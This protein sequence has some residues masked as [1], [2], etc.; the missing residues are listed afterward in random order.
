MSAAKD[1]DEAK[2][3]KAERTGMFCSGIVWT[4]EGH[5]IVLF[6][7]GRKHARE[8]LA[9]YLQLARDFLIS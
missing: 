7:S 5:K 8:I 9:H 2:K 1:G 4:H 6:L 3:T